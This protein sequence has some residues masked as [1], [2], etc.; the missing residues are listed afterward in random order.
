MCD[1]LVP[2]A[3]PSFQACLSGHFGGPKDV[4]SLVNQQRT[5]PP[6]EVPSILHSFSL[7]FLESHANLYV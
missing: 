3:D 6:G 2:P 5:R 7:Y 1:S 4:G